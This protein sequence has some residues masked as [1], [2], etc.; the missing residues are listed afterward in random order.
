MRDEGWGGHVVQAGVWDAPVI[1][2]DIRLHEGKEE[3]T[4]GVH[5]LMLSAVHMGTC[6]WCVGGAGARGGAQGQS[7]GD[8]THLFPHRNGV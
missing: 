5:D 4:W 1:G 7:R 6:T 3:L 2:F 8:T